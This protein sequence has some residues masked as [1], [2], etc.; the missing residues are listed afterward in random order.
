MTTIEKSENPITIMVKHRSTVLSG[1]IQRFIGDENAV[2]FAVVD[3]FDG[4]DFS[5]HEQMFTVFGEIDTE[6]LELFSFE[7]PVD[8]FADAVVEQVAVNAVDI[9]GIIP[10]AFKAAVFD[11]D[12]AAAVGEVSGIIGN[13]NKPFAAGAQADIHAQKVDIET[14]ALLRSS[15]YPDLQ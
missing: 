15:L 4:V 8:L 2:L 11:G 10:L 13:G 14:S 3:F 9:D 6:L 5:G 1:G 12:P 7:I